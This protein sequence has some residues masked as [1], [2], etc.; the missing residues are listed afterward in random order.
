[1]DKERLRELAGIV[2]DV[3]DVMEYVR[4]MAEAKQAGTSEHKYVVV[5]YDDGYFNVVGPFSARKDAERYSTWEAGHYDLT[6]DEKGQVTMV[7]GP[8]W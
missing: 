8:D 5:T 3:D 6:E 2:E 1:M 4:Q 7:Q